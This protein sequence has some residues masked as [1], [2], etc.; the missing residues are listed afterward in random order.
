MYWFGAPFPSASEQNDA[1]IDDDLVGVNLAT[2][3]WNSR[4]DAIEAM[5]G[6]KHREAAKLASVSPPSGAYFLMRVFG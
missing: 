5:R 6:E 2:C 3:I 1:P 4:R